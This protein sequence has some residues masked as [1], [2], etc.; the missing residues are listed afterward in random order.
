MNSSTPFAEIE[1]LFYRTMDAPES[2]RAQLIEQ[3]T[4]GN[5]ALREEVLSLVNAVAAADRL[6]TNSSSH[7]HAETP[8]NF[9]LAAG[10]RVGAFQLDRLL[11]KGGMGEVYAGHRVDGELQQ[12]VAIKVVA[13]RLDSPELRNIFFRERDTLARLQHPH[14]ARLLDG[15]V[16]AG[17]SPYLVMEMVGDETSPAERLDVYCESRRLSPRARV[18]VVVSI[19]DAVSFAHRKLIVHGDVKPGNVL[20]TANG[21]PKLLDFGASRL[22]AQDETES[23]PRALTPRYASPEQMRGKPITVASDV[24]SMGKLLERVLGPSEDAELVGVIAKSTREEPEDRYETMERLADDLRAWTEFR[25]LQACAGRR[26]YALR[27]WLRRNRKAVIA[28][29][30]VLLALS[31]CIVQTQRSAR[32]A[33]EERDHAISSAKAVEALAH[34]LLFDLQP[35]LKEIGSSTEAQHQVA[36]T[37]LAYLNGL[38]LDPSLSSE[39]L[40]LDMANAYER[41]GNLLGNPYDENLGQPKEAVAALQK[42][43]STASA[44]AR[45]NPTSREARFSLA[46]AQTSLAE[47]EFGAGDAKSALEAMTESAKNFQQLVQASDATVPQLLEASSTL[48]SLGDVY[49]LPG[50]A[51]LDRTKEAVDCYRQAYL[52]SERVLKLDPSNVRA[53]RGLAIDDYKIANLILEADPNAAIAGLQKAIGNLSLLPK[54]IQSGAPIVRLLLL[55]DGHMSRAYF[56]QGKISDAI[57]LKRHACEQAAVLVARDPLDSRARYDLATTVASL[58]DFLMKAG[59]RKEARQAY[60]QALQNFKFMLKRDPDNRILKDHRQELEKNL[61]DMDRTHPAQKRSP[62]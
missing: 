32:R 23:R 28:S 39:S 26:G 6:R 50:S 10:A 30:V 58:G 46:K 54:G 18:A 34:R 12:A 51:S 53:R 61:L 37:T 35:Q 9:G 48:G 5:P 57:V 60:Q 13:A 59:N 38:S 43:V 36:D 45:D 29:V 24:Y 31:G 20:V 40:R 41:M 49:G 15:G 19:S 8:F 22:L 16:T 27:K 4:E 14:I 47:V 21:I 42:A 1:A 17:H 33:I 3:S 2:E 56:Q 44:L 25:P 55:I 11:G 7:Q 62:Q 52:L